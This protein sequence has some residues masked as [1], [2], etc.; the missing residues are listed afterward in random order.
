MRKKPKIG[1]EVAGVWHQGR[2]HSARVT[3]VMQKWMIVVLP[4]EM[5]I[6]MGGLEEATPGRWRNS[7]GKLQWSQSQKAYTYQRDNFKYI[8]KYCDH[9]YTVA[10]ITHHGEV[11]EHLIAHHPEQ[12][13]DLLGGGDG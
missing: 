3:K 12:Y 11:D 10:G 5:K 7:F 8:C 9:R 6:P 13:L 1:D 4:Y 2:Q